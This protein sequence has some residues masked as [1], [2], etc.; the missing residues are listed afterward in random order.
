MQHAGSKHLMECPARWA[1]RALPIERNSERLNRA[2]WNTVPPPPPPPH[3]PRLIQSDWKTCRE[4]KKKRK[5]NLTW[6][7]HD[8]VRGQLLLFI[9]VDRLRGFHY[10]WMPQRMRENMKDAKSILCSSVENS[11][12]S[13]ACTWNS[14]SSLSLCVREYFYLTI[15]LD[16]YHGRDLIWNLPLILVSGLRRQSWYLDVG[17]DKHHMRRGTALTWSLTGATHDQLKRHVTG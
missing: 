9:C 7:F 1:N 15:S 10:D 5:G 8:V 17:I 11:H 6:L 13:N 14:E 2:T 12:K 3:P 16:S 4:K